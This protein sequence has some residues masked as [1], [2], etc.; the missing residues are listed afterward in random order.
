MVKTMAVAQLLLPTQ[1]LVTSL[2]GPH[3]FQPFHF[4]FQPPSQPFPSVDVLA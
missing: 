2:D 4:T 3:Y 1:L